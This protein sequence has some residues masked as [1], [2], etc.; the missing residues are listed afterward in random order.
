MCL[1]KYISAADLIEVGDAVAGA[2]ILPGPGHSHFVIVG[3][4]PVITPPHQGIPNVHCRSG[5]PKQLMLP[6]IMGASSTEAPE[7]MREKVG[8]H[9]QTD[10]ALVIARWLMRSFGSGLVSMQREFEKIPLCCANPCLLADFG[11]FTLQ[12]P[13][14]QDTCG[15]KDECCRWLITAGITIIAPLLPIKTRN[16]AANLKMTP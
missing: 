13:P 1:T 14:R 16:M 6:T 9:M 5:K 11:A 10:T 15:I 3:L 12:T 8:M 7:Q 2:L 4:Q